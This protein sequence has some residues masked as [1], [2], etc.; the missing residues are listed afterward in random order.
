MLA[1]LNPKYQTPL[2]RL[3]FVNGQIAQIKIHDAVWLVSATW[4]GESGGRLY[5]WN[6]QTHQ[7]F[8]REMPQGV[9]G[10]FFLQTGIDNRLYIGDGHGDLHRY[11]PK[12]DGIHTLVKGVMHNITW[13]GCVTDRY[14]VWS[15]TNEAAV[16]DWRNEKFIKKFS[17]VDQEK[18]HAQ[19]GHNVI[20]APDG[21]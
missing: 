3:P 15:A 17:P 16:Y 7:H 13:G 11:D 1:K 14:V 21:K 4:G 9:P 6:P 19:Y 8:M 10:A 18:P 12:E 2:T 20:E 5:F